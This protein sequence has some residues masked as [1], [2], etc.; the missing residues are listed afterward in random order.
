MPDILIGQEGSD[1][2]VGGTGSDLYVLQQ[3]KGKDTV[4]GFD[5]NADK[6]VLGALS[7][8]DIRMG[9]TGDGNSTNIIIRSTNDKAMVLS[10]V[11]SSLISESDFMSLG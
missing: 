2:L 11:Q 8:S 4:Q 1:T 10:N 9:T 3:N 7:F 6:I 5:I